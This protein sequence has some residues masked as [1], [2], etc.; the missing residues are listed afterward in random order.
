MRVV[1]LALVVVQI[2]GNLIAEE[3]RVRGSEQEFHMTQN[4]SSIPGSLVQQKSALNASAQIGAKDPNWEF[5]P[6]F[7]EIGEYVP[8]NK[9][10]SKF[11][12]SKGEPLEKMKLKKTNGTKTKRELKGL[13]ETAKAK[14]PGVVKFA[15]INDMHFEPNYTQVRTQ[16]YQEVKS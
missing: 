11:I 2:S 4:T 6:Y 1:L 13:N 8:D 7:D 16:K 14:D 12:K 10:T 15:F 5:K 9:S 3:E